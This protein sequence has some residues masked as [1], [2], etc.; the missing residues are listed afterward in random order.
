MRSASG[1]VLQ[2]LHDL[3]ERVWFENIVVIEKADP[4]A[5]RHVPARNWTPLKCRRSF[6][7]HED[8]SRIATRDGGE[9]LERLRQG[10]AVVD[11]NQLPFF[12]GLIAGPNRSPLSATPPAY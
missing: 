4:F 12:V 5:A 11:Q 1:L 9:Q 2:I 8:N 3:E 6:P 10:G 7:S